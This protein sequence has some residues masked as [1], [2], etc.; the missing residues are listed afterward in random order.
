MTAPDP[1]AGLGPGD[2]RRAAPWFIGEGIVLVV[3]GLAAA[4]L[5]GIAGLAGVIVFGWVLLAV[6]IAGFLI[7]LASRDHAHWLWTT[8]SALTALVTGALVL[9]SPIVGIIALATLIAAYLLIDAVALI[10]MG[11]DQRKLGAKG[12]VWLVVSGGVD[13]LLAA[14]I[15]ALRP[16]GDAHLMGFIIAFDLFIAGLALITLGWMS[17]K[18]V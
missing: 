15:L 18:P 9:W 6:G 3:L 16:A 13:V 2:R 8:L 4:A 17:R 14:F 11:L 5:P 10:G 12:W 1:L 7:M